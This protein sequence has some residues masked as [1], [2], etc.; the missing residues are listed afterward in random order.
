MDEPISA[1]VGK[2]VGKLAARVCPNIRDP[3]Q[4][5][6]LQTAR[7]AA[8]GVY[9]LASRLDSVNDPAVHA[10]VARTIQHISM[11][12]DA[13]RAERQ[14]RSSKPELDV[15]RQEKTT[16]VM[17]T[18]SLLNNPCRIE[19][20]LEWPVQLELF[21]NITDEG[22]WVTRPLKGPSGV[23]PVHPLSEGQHQL[24]VEVSGGSA[25]EIQGGEI[26]NSRE[27]PPRS[28]VVR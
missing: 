21:V 1:R 3:E 10:C 9:E 8:R 26:L 13:A 2:Y 18:R 15:K 22:G 7:E 6:V 25:L 5:D 28:I 11:L 14:R 19:N 16:S 24:F 20:R 12:R 17:P 4:V 27:M 23:V